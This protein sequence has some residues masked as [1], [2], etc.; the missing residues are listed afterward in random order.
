MTRVLIRNTRNTRET[1]KYGVAKL[2]LLPPYIYFIINSNSSSNF[3]RYSR[4]RDADL[5]DNFHNFTSDLVECFDLFNSQFHQ[6]LQ[7]DLKL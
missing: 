4:K 1:E 2:E 3:R 6:I 5:R 7:I